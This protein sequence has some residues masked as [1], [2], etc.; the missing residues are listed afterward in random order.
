M[1]TKKIPIY[2]VELFVVLLVLLFFGLKAQNVGALFNSD[3][4]YLPV[5]LSDLLNGGRLTDWYL[6]PSPYLF[7]DLIL[8]YLISI[9]PIEGY[10]SIVSFAVLQVLI[11]SCA[12]RHMLQ[13]LSIGKAR[14]IHAISIFVMIFAA[15]VF[16]KAYQYILISAHHF[17]VVTV[18]IL[19]F[20]I[21]FKQASSGVIATVFAMTLSFLMGLSDSLYIVQFSIPLAVTVVVVSCIYGG[22]RHFVICGLL[23]LSS[24]LGY[25]A[26]SVF[27]T[28]PMRYNADI[29]LAKF[30]K[31]IR[32]YSMLSKVDRANFILLALVMIVGTAALVR[33]EELKKRLKS[34]GFNQGFAFIFAC[35]SIAIN[36]LVVALTTNLEASDRYFIPAAVLSSI[37]L[38]IYLIRLDWLKLRW[39]IAS[40]IV[41]ISVK[42]FILYDRNGLTFNYETE[43][44][45]CLNSAVREFSLKSGIAEYW[46]AKKYQFLIRDRIN[47]AQFTYDNN[48]YLW[49]TSSR[50]FNKSHT[51][52]LISDE[53]VPAN[54][55]N[56]ESMIKANGAPTHF[57]QC[58]ST[59]LYVYEKPIKFGSSYEQ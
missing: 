39:L 43:K 19:I 22:R 29:G 24:V 3:A 2:F 20:C 42:F 13:C 9:F 7:P 18:S 16:G 26:Y 53:S 15:V 37:G 51:F 27:I 46:D 30:I 6:T 31:L 21:I 48:P 36:S 55:I 5:L 25:L 38:A 4:L 50:F 40:L 49:I 58:E 56:Y 33:L 41:L 52:A 23:F 57:R 54:K 14:G 32:D 44:T 35:V 28:N 12:L 8:F 34:V 59:T 45:E 10:W 1:D 11:Y 17:S 47:L